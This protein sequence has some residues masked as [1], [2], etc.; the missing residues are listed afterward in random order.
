VPG[1]ARSAIRLRVDDPAS[2]ARPAAVD[3]FASAPESAVLASVEDQR[4]W[5]ERWR[6]SGIGEGGSS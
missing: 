2:A 4:A 5:F 6:D 1:E 3:I